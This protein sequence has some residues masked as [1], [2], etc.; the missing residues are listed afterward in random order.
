MMHML[1]Q[2]FVNPLPRLQFFQA[3]L[4]RGSVQLPSKTLSTRLREKKKKSS[5]R[6]FM[7]HDFV[8]LLISS[9]ALVLHPEQSASLPE[10]IQ[11]MSSDSLLGDHNRPCM[12]LTPSASKT[13][14]TCVLPAL[15]TAALLLFKTFLCFFS[16]RQTAQ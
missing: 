15:H 3:V 5:K 14:S 4:S 9:Q 10:E 12:C 6:V 2:R 11:G 7:A 13:L 1:S 16:N 8:T